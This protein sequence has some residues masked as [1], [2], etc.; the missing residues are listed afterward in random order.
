MRGF[1]LIGLACLLFLILGARGITADWVYYGE[2][3]SEFYKAYYDKDSVKIK[4]DKNVTVWTKNVYSETGRNNLIDERKK[5]GLPTAEFENLDYAVWLREINCIDRKSAAISI[6]Y[7]SR[8]RQAIEWYNFNEN[9]PIRF[10]P[11]MPE[12]LLEGLFE[13][14]CK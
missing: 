11:I 10:K 13:L 4:P 9:G 3:N 7:Y 6:T 12:S 2:S 1:R 5:Y 14:T 8:T